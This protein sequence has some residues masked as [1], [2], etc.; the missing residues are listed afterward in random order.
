MIIKATRS[1]VLKTEAKHIAFAINKEGYNG[2]G[3]SGKV[4]NTYWSELAA[5]GENEI[6]T[7]FS[8]KV[9]DKTFHAVVCYSLEEGWEEDQVSLIKRCFDKINVPDGEEISTV[10]IGTGLIGVR[11]GADFQQILKGLNLSNKNIVLHSGF[12][13][14]EVMK[15]CD[16]EKEVFKKLTKNSNWY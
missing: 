11:T 4:L 10:A 9:G 5:Y 15:I 13:Y 3:L 7:V 12:T 8:K 1:D 16:E 14:D 6:G 2:I